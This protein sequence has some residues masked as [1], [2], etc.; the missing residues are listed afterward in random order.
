MSSYAC[1]NAYG[2]TSTR[3]SE[4]GLANAVDIRGFLTQ[5]GKS[6]RL[7]T[8]W[9][10]TARDV[11]ERIIA[12][13][14]KAAEEAAARAK[15]AARA[16]LRASRSGLAVQ[17][18]GRKVGPAGGGPGERDGAD[19]TSSPV[20]DS[21]VSKGKPVTRA[22]QAKK[23]DTSDLKAIKAPRPKTNAGRFL[24]AAHRTACRLFGT[25][26]GPEANEAHRDHF[27]VDLA[28][29][30]RSNYCR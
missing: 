16:A 25:V 29:R 9:G 15:K 19:K 20:P 10:E 30:K 14:K 21:S 17:G 8:D 18:D 2:R 23:I 27:H 4:H 28:K 7:T 1:R 12:A 22:L 5:S 3:L 6:V 24:R 26:L 11:R 13:R